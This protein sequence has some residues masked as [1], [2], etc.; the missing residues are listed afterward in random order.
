MKRV[1]FGLLVVVGITAFGAGGA[2]AAPAPDTP[3]ARAGSSVSQP[4]TPAYYVV[5]R[6]YY[7]PRGGCRRVRVC[8]PYRCVWRRRCW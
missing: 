8:G 3:L 1:I 2:T 7:G 4:F 5:R 6:G